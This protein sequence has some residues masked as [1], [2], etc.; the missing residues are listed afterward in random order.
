MWENSMQKPLDI[1]KWYA[2]FVKTGQ[3]DKVKLRLEYRFKEQLAILVPK[4][5]LKE[6]KGGI[7]RFVTR[8]LFPG[9]VLVN[10]NLDSHILAKFKDIPGLLMLLKSESEPLKIDFHEMEVLSRL[11]CN[12]EIIGISDIFV[13]NERVRVADGPLVSLEGFIVS[14]DRRKGRARVQL[15]FLNEPRIVELGVNVLK[16]V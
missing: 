12:S 13:E 2:L 16:P 4:R 10:G 14:V 9:Y 6:R 7:W 15:N 11:I 1:E 8:T 3:E 5:R